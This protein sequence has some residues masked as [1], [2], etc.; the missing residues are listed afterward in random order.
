[1]LREG[2]SDQVRMLQKN[3]LVRLFIPLDMQTAFTLMTRGL[4]SRPYGHREASGIGV[5]RVL[6]VEY[7]PD[8]AAKEGTVVVQVFV[9]GKNLYPASTTT[10]EVN[11]ASQKYPDSFNPAVTMALLDRR[12]ETEVFL[13]GQLGIDDVIKV[14][15][16]GYDAEGHR[17][18]GHAEGVVQDEFTAEEFLQWHQGY[19][20]RQAQMRSGT[21][22]GS[23]RDPRKVIGR[24]NRPQGWVASDD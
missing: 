24:M 23:S 10:R 14:M 2:M 19:L 3:T 6:E 16:I 1:M 7:Y 17:L 20:S 11:I 9:K 21:E 18:P 12:D 5:V 15:L 13:N 8:R 22:P 4:D